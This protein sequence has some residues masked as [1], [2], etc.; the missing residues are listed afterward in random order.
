M[1]RDRKDRARRYQYSSKQ[2]KRAEAQS[3]IM[4][5]VWEESGDSKEPSV[6]GASE[7]VRDSSGGSGPSSHRDRILWAIVRTSASAHVR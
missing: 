5:G 7:H 1:P 2:M 4:P 3:K 6:L